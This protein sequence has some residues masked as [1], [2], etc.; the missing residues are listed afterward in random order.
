MLTTLDN[1]IHCKTTAYMQRKK[2]ITNKFMKNF[3]NYS[4][5][6]PYEPQCTPAMTNQV[7]YYQES[8]F[9]TI[10]KQIIITVNKNASLYALLQKMPAYS[11]FH[12]KMQQ[13]GHSQ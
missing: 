13:L 8:R 12:L 2:K 10:C 9:R 3:Q 1:N 5:K 6:I 7:C 4:K 11:Y